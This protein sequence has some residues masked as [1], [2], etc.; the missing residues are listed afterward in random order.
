MGV[1]NATPLTT[2]TTMTTATAILCVVI[3]TVAANG[4]NLVVPKIISHAIDAYT[5]RT[6]R[7]TNQQID[8]VCAGGQASRVKPR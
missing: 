4:L 7:T 8:F 6:F 2:E 3:L 1:V 5:Q